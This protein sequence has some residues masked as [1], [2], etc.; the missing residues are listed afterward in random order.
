M[1]RILGTTFGENMK[2]EKIKYEETLMNNN[3]DYDNKLF[4][5]KMKLSLERIKLNY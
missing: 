4:E 1:I 3:G 2:L 5:M